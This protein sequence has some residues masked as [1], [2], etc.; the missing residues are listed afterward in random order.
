[1]MISDDFLKKLC[2]S[3]QKAAATIIDN[4]TY[5]R[6]PLWPVRLLIE[7]E[8]DNCGKVEKENSSFAV[9]LID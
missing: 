1:M 6:W 4:W 3:N 9:E 7:R 8:Y 2:F 5:F